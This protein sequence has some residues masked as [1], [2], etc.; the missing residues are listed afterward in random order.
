MMNEVFSAQPLFP[1]L[2]AGG[3]ALLCERDGTIREVLRDDVLRD[4]VPR[5]GVELGKQLAAGGPLSLLD[6]VDPGSREKAVLFLNALQQSGAVFDW[7][8]NVPV[9]KR[10]H[11]FYF[12]GAGIQS[13]FLILA[14]VGRPEVTNLFEDM[15]RIHNEQ[16]NAFRSLGKA[17]RQEVM[18]AGEARGIPA[19]GATLGLFEEITRAN[20][21]LANTQRELARRNAQLQR[22]QQQLEEANVRLAAANALLGQQ[23]MTDGLTGLSNRRAFDL[24]LGEEFARARR[25]NLPLALVLLDV[26]RFKQYN[27]TFGHPAGDAVLRALAPIL[28]SAMRSCDVA[29]RFGGEEFVLLLPHVEQ[30]GVL[31]LAQRLGTLIRR[32]EWPLRAVTASF[33]VAV[34]SAQ[35]ECADD[36]VAAADTALYAAKKGGRDRVETFDASMPSPDAAPTV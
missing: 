3:F 13:G 8:I 9:G 22:L 36:L 1:Q 20:N 12:A 35:I 25:Y 19:P 15:A 28:T 24:R 7:E 30:T 10:L 26:D 16:M 4:D 34:L 29:A 21:D 33:G 6:V 5:D 14:S 18:G 2:Q 32:H 27:D 23:A 31:S 11:A 17:S